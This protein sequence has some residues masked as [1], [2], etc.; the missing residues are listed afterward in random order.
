MAGMKGSQGS[1]NIRTWFVISRTIASTFTMIVRFTGSP[2]PLHLSGFH[3]GFTAS[4]ELVG[5]GAIAIFRFSSDQPNSRVT[6]SET[7]LHQSHWKKV[8]FSAERAAWYPHMPCTPPPGGV[9]AE[10]K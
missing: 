4:G 10:H 8:F 6:I 7:T 2:V 3:D 9:E 5:S 1:G